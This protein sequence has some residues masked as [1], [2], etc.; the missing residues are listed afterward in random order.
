MLSSYRALLARDGARPLAL[1]CALGWISL[2]GYVPAMVLAVH[3]ATGSF[4]AAGITLAAFSIGSA[5]VAPVRGRSIDRGGP[6]V[7]GRFAGAHLV[8]GVTFAIACGLRASTTQLVVIAAL[9]G[10]VSP[11]LMATARTLWTE[12]GDE[13]G[14]RN[15]HA[16][17]AMLADIGVVTGPGI[18]GALAAL[19]SPTVGAGLLIA[20]AAIAAGLV[21]RIGLR[22]A[23]RRARPPAAGP[24]GSSSGERPRGGGWGVLRDSA[25]LRTLAVTDLAIGACLAGVEVA[26]IAVAARAGDAS[27]GVL[28]IAASALGSITMSAWVGSRRSAHGPDVRFCA[29]LV[30]VAVV[31]PGSLISATVPA[32]TGVLI[33]SG[34]GFGLFNAA[35]FELLDQVVPAR[36]ATEAFTWLTT[37]NAGG[38]A[39]G[40][41]VAGHLAQHAP[42]VALLTVT[43]C[44]AVAA[45]VSLARRSTLRVPGAGRC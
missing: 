26:V 9:L 14:A 34:A 31:L 11:P 5:A 13:T 4:A 43:G 22:G 20:G 27:L 12:L 25:G 24:D 29:G 33:L 38:S 1:A 21:S 41:A 39:V 8:A 28:P 18:A 15:A 30:L 23:V 19:G 7:L 3:A 45:V 36:Q 42:E 16:L 6:G 37:S 17:N 40:A 44:A 32:L 2:C 35:L 10:V